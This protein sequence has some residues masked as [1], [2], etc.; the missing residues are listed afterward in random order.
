MTR[1]WGQ[2]IF[3]VEDADKFWTYL[4]EKEFHPDR[5]RDAAWGE[6]YFHLYDPDGRE[7]SF[8]PTNHL[9]YNVR[10]F[11][12]GTALLLRGS[13]ENTASS[14]GVICETRAL[15]DAVIPNDTSTQRR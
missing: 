6:R 5:P 11:K 15:P 9:N 7:L 2:I 1:D 8:C 3:Y 14:S 4:K 13:W 10:W 12:F